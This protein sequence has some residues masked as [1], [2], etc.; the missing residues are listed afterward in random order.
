MPDKKPLVLIVDDS[1]LNIQVLGEALR[2]DYRLKVA[3]NGALA[4]QLAADQ[5][6]P[7]LI[8]LDIMMPDLDGYEVCKRLKDNDVTKNIPVIF[9]TAKNTGEEMTKGFALGAVDYIVKPFYTPVVLAR[10]RTHVNLKLKA[11][12][13]ESLVMRDDLTGIPNRRYFN[14]AYDT[15]WKRAQRAG[16][17]LA[18][19][20]MDVDHFKDYNDNYGHG[21]GDVCLRKVATAL[22]FSVARPGDLVARYG[23]EEFSAILPKTD[24]VGARDVA[25]RF[26][27]GVEAVRIAH[28][29]SKASA[30]VTISVGYA[31]AI[32]A[33]SLTPPELLGVADRMLYRAKRGGR[34]CVSGPDL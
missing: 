11:E 12:L 3:S 27:A 7:D 10:V 5:D 1:P 8:L 4:L 31:A 6:A 24:L 18:V 19:I 23:G 17:W 15:E 22:A 14:E 28:S 21:L 16:D 25:E 29:H 32:P 33:N 2:A 34:N 26:R 9:V 30:V 13:L 20:V